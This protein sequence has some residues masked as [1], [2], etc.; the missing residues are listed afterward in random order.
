MTTTAPSGLTDHLDALAAGT[1][2]VDLVQRTLD[3][4]DDSQR[5][6]NAF[7]V[8]R[9]DAALADAADADRRR[10]AGDDAP[11][12]GVP[13]AIKDDTDIIGETTEFGCPGLFRP[14]TADSAVVSRLRAAGAVIVGKT[15]TPE[16]GQWPLTGGHFGQTRNPWGR[17]H[18]PGGSSGGSAAAVAAGLVPVALGSD[19]AGSVRIPAAWCNLVGIK[20]Q[21]GRISSY[22][23][24]ESF[25][26]LT[27]VGPLARTVADAALLLDVL[28]GSVDGDL[29]RPAPTTVSDAVGRDP[30]SLRIALSL[31]SAYAPFTITLDP[32]VRAGVYRIADALRSLGHRVSV[33]DPHYG[34]V[35]GLGFLP[36][37]MAGIADWVDRLPD[38][39]VIDPRTRANARN[40]KLARGR[41]LRVARAAERLAQKQIGRIFDAYDIVLAPTTASSPL[42]LDAIDG[43]SNSA[44]DRVV[45]S[46]CPYTWPWNV[47][48]WPSVNIPAGFTGDR[49]PVG[50]QLMGPDSSERLLVSVA[51]QLES[52]LRWDVIRPEKWW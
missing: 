32:D 51:A 24:P 23:D 13:V 7:R 5:S 28:Q 12:L 47:L 49:L 36:R 50:V 2:S 10:A 42:P 46:A 41:V 33:D 29:H 20:P 21:R 3:R 4:I 14:A 6:L 16:I 39:T 25:H 40:G 48:G 30:G 1:R 37:S 43:L 27:V 26:G 45:T 52:I 11:L 31:R 17:E 15:T 9:R 44:T 38:T 34:V 19:G 18:T 22:P 8:V 35:A